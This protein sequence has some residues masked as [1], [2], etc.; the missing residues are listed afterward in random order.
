MEEISC[1][2]GCGACCV[3][4]SIASPLPGMP[5]GKPA[6]VRCIHLTEQNFCMLYGKPERPKVCESYQA[7]AEL[8]GGCAREAFERIAR[9]DT[10]EIIGPMGP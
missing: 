6:G 9:L 2:A 1:R 5:E 3:V 4:L 10:E 8:C 7:T